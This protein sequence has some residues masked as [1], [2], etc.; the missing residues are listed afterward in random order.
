MIPGDISRSREMLNGV[1][2]FGAVYED[3]QLKEAGGRPQ[4]FGQ[5]LSKISERR[6]RRNA[7]RGILFCE[8]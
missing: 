5:I 8:T 2:D 4:R 6:F 3:Q 1:A 7:T